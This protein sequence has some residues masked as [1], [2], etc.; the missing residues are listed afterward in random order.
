MCTGDRE[1]PESHAFGK[2]EKANVGK[3]GVGKPQHFHIVL[4][5]KLRGARVGEFC[6]VEKEVEWLPPVKTQVAGLDAI[7]WAVVG[8]RQHGAHRHGTRDKLGATTILR[9]EGDQFKT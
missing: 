3:L 7:D 5:E 8:Q 2:F 9:A 6:V 1:F 4:A